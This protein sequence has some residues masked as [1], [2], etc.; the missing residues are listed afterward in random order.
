MKFLGYNPDDGIG[1]VE[2][3]KFY[4]KYLFPISKFLDRI[5]FKYFLGKNI[6]LVAEK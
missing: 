4:D 6:V 3:M 2:S 1:S 5:G